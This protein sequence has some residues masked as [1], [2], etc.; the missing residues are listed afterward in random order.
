MT[1]TD[2][3]QQDVTRIAL[4]LREAPHLALAGGGAMNA[5]GFI[6]RPTAD[7]DLFTPVAAELA[8]VVASLTAA[9]VQRGYRVEPSR[10]EPTFTRLLVVDPVGQ[11]GCRDRAHARMRPPVT[12]VV[13]AVLD[14]EELCADK[15]LA[16]FGLAAEKDPGFNTA[17]FA[18]ARLVAAAR[19]AADFDH[20][21]VD[22]AQLVRLQVFVT[23]WTGEL[24][25]T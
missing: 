1:A 5:H 24:P 20:V 2:R 4:A 22:A 17:V 21:G 25:D 23:D 15:T 11:R 14:P 12:L 6:D 8:P 9:L 10:E 7:V 13:G 16:L 3:L 18:S 19:P